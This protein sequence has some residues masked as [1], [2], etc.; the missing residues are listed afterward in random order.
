MTISSVAIYVYGVTFIS[1]R[2][3]AAGLTCG[4]GSL[5]ESC[6]FQLSG[7]GTATITPNTSTWQNCTVKF[8]ATGQFIS[9]NQLWRWTGGSILAGGTTPTDLL[10]TTAIG[11]TIED[12]DLSNASSTMNISSATVTGMRLTMRNCKMPTSWTGNLTGTSGV[13]GSPNIVQL[14]ACDSSGTNYILHRETQWGNITNE[15]TFVRTGGAT[16]GTTA[17]SWKMVSVASTVFPSGAL[18]TG[19]FVIWNDTT[20]ASKT[21]TVE[22]LHDNA[23][24]LK[25]NEIWLELSYYG[26]SGNPLGTYI[27]SAPNALAAGSTLSSSSATWATGGMA[28]PN[29]Q[30]M[31]L[32]FTPQLKGFFIASVKLGKASYTAYVDPIMTVT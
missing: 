13:T 27:D 26:A 4:S 16:D 22:F 1:S 31:S 23:T 12:V 19:E 20:G 25:D 11:G 28:N 2:T 15:T 7:T 5:M 14:M 8:A 10:G 9:G 21:V 18:Q 29:K 30:K 3:S 6:S 17:I 24:G 32:T